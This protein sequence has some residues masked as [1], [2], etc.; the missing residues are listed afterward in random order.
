MCVLILNLETVL[1]TN[2]SSLLISSS[3]DDHPAAST[4][5]ST[6][7][8]T[9][10]TSATAVAT[11]AV[12]STVN[13][14]NQQQQQ[15]QV[16]T[17]TKNVKKSPQASS[18]STRIQSK[19]KATPTKIRPPPASTNKNLMKKPQYSS[20]QVS[21]TS[22]LSRTASKDDRTDPGEDESSQSE[23][24]IQDQ[25]DLKRIQRKTRKTRRPS[26][27]D[28]KYAPEKYSDRETASGGGGS[29]AILRKKRPNS[30]TPS[31]MS[32]RPRS[33][34]LSTPI[35]TSGSSS[36]AMNKSSKSPRAHSAAMTVQK[37]WRGH[38]AKDRGD[39][40]KVNQLK[41]EVRNLRTEEHIKHLTKELANA[42]QALERERKL[43]ALQMD[44]IKVLWK[45]VQLMDEA[46]SSSSVMQ[47]DFHQD[48]TRPSG[49]GGSK[50]SSRSSE[51]S[52]AKLM[53]TLQATAGVSPQKPQDSG[54][55][56]MAQS[57]PASVLC[58]QLNTEVTAVESLSKTCNSLQNQVEQLQS[59]LVGVM[60]FMSNFQQPQ[61][62]QPH[63]R[64]RHSSNESSS[65]SYFQPIQMTQSCLPSGPMSLPL[66]PVVIR[67]PIN[68]QQP[69][70][71]S[72]TEN[73]C[74]ATSRSCDCL[75]QTDISAVLTPRNEQM[76][77]D[78]P[79]AQLLQFKRVD[80]S[81]ETSDSE[82]TSSG[83]L[84][85]PTSNMQQLNQHQSR[86]LLKE[87]QEE[88]SRSGGGARSRSKSPRPQ[89]LPGL[90]K[91]S[92]S[93]VAL[94]PESPQTATTT[95]SHRHSLIF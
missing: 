65:F 25:K 31:L 49:R 71:S 37:N 41:E 17:A 94:R 42:K 5:A 83:R 59:S 66:N 10:T 68:I 21:D 15:P 60:Q 13:K 23:A 38:L 89:T 12:S 3:S 63:M 32:S 50:I 54:V 40:E 47:A 27:T 70:R 43:R 48:V 91:A 81:L 57:M 73:S 28:Q 67:P 72:C 64:Q 90:V 1:I 77:P 20:K 22:R 9:P 78:P 85:M 61:E 55:V 45:E 19:P 69:Q 79:A 46:R 7:T 29:S 39:A 92:E 11:T 18:S 74:L 76:P 51:H 62:P 6:A 88:A 36:A 75:T 16:K 24:S 33:N 86:L 56:S 44:A 30:A 8:V 4:T 80:I 34:T 26:Q 52:I 87:D 93:Q 95:V 58:G 84:R 14:T 82:A 35:S 53:E 2:V